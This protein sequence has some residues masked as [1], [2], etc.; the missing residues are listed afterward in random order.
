M[1]HFVEELLSSGHNNSLGN[2]NITERNN[3]ECSSTKSTDVSKNNHS[4]LEI[5]GDRMET[6]VAYLSDKK[7]IHDLVHF[8]ASNIDFSMPYGVTLKELQQL[9]SL[10]T[11]F[12]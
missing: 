5:I 10:R 12:G 3:V 8:D 2:E 4:S 9:F 1:Q 6:L 11:E 7:L